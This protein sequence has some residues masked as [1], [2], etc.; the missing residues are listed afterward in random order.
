MAAGIAIMNRFSGRKVGE[1]LLRPALGAVRVR[2]DLTALEPR[3][4]G[5]HWVLHGAINP[6]QDQQSQAEVGGVEDT[7][8]V[9]GSPAEF[10]EMSL[11][12]QT[13]AKVNADEQE[14]GAARISERSISYGSTVLEAFISRADATDAEKAAARAAVASRLARAQAATDG[15]TIYQQLQQSAAAVNRLYDAEVVQL[16]VHHEERVSRHPVTFEATRAGRIR[17]RIAS[18][19]ANNVANLRPEERAIA[20]ETDPARRR[21]LIREWANQL[22][23]KEMEG[24]PDKLEEVEMD[25]MTREAHLGGVHGRR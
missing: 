8:E 5:T 14:S 21:V 19:I 12:E 2:Y 11:W 22:L 23:E 15:H 25:V 1:A 7:G 18:R 4:Q 6:E 10:T 9:A 3:A 13:A 17:A 20:A 16:Q 24:A